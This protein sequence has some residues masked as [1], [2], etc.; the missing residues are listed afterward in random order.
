MSIRYRVGVDIGGTFTDFVLY[1]ALKGAF[2][3]HKRL[4]TADHPSHAALVGLKEVTDFAG[5]TLREVGE[6]VHGTT[7]VSN[8]LIERKGAKTGL[9][10]TDGFRDVLELGSEQRYDIY[11]LFL[12]FP[13][14]LVPRDLRLE[15]MERIDSGGAVV[16][17]LDI[18]S[19]RNALSQFADAGVESVAVCF[20]HSYR[21]AKHE[22]CVEEL[23]SREFPELSVSLS[24]AVDP[25]IREYPRCVTTCANAYVRPIVSRYLG[26]IESGLRAA[27]F[28]GS[29]RLMH[30]GGGMLSLETARTFPIRLLESGPAGGCLVSALFGA[31]SGLTDVIGF[32]M[33]GTTAKACLVEGGRIETIPLIEIAR[34][35]R[36]TKGSGLP[37][38]TPAVDMVEV[39]AGGGSIASI[40]DA[41]LLKV[42]PESAGANPGPA[43]YGM[44][45]DHPTVTDANLLLGYYNP[46][47][48]LGG[49]MHLDGHASERAFERVTEPLGLT[50]IEAASGVRKLVN[51]NM[52]SAI[53][54]H[55][56]ERGK[57]PRNYAIV[58]IGGA[59]PAHVADVA[60]NVGAT[61]AIVPP[62]SGAASALGFLS[63]P[64]SFEVIRSFLTE[65]KEDFACNAV[66]RLLNELEI[67][68]RSH[69]AGTGFEH[70]DVIVERMADMRLVGQTHEIVV[71]LPKG[72]LGPGSFAEIQAAFNAAYEERY[73][74]VNQNSQ[75][76]AINFRVRCSAP[77][78][79]LSI[80]SI[81]KGS[82]GVAKQKSTR[83][84]YFDEGVWETPVYN[85]YALDPGD[86]INGPAIIEEC[87]ST[88]VLSPNDY[89]I[90]DDHRNLCIS[91]A[92][93]KPRKSKVGADPSIANAIE[94]IEDDSVS[95]EIMWAR[96]INVVEE[97]WLTVRRTAYSLVISEAQDFACDLLDSD[98]ETLAHSPRAMPVFNLTLPNAVKGVLAKFPASTLNPGDV[99]ITNDPW[100][101]AGHLFDV[102][103]ITPAFV[104]G[105]LIGILATVGNVAD[106]GGTKDQAH[107]REI[108]DEG[109]QIP[110]MKLFDAGKPNQTLVQLL[111]QNVR[112]SEHI[113]GDIYSFV[114][115]NAIGVDRLT[116]F[117]H[118]YRI[119]DLRALATVIQRK[120][121]MAMRAAIDAIPDGEYF[122]AA[123]NNPNGDK[124]RYPLKLTVRG[125]DIHLDFDGAPP[126]SPQGG[127]NCPLNYTKAH[128]TYPLKCMLT[129]RM[130]GNSGCY[131]PFSVSAPPGSV[132]NAQRPAAVGLRQRT[133]WYLAP[134]IFGGLATALPDRVQANTGLPFTCNIHGHRADGQVYSD[135]FFM[136]GGQ[137]ASSTRDGI[138]GLLWPT[139]ASNTSVEL[140]ESRI[141]ILVLEK[142]YIPDSGGAG[143]HRGGLGQRLSMRK[144]ANDGLSTFAAVYPEG[145]ELPVEGLFGGKP[146]I[147]ASARVIDSAGRHRQS[148]GCGALVEL[149]DVSEIL[150]VIVSGGS[151]YGDRLE[152]PKKLVD[153]DVQM[154]FVSEAA[155]EE[156]YA[157]HSR[158]GNCAVAGE[159]SDR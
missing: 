18:C 94:I 68:A 119:R 154:G 9:I 28:C 159:R 24:S 105:H 104:S 50:S 108:Y 17:H 58:G 88:T 19:L 51:E 133:G 144:L 49:C 98:G 23:A 10:T 67:E 74:Q 20:L 13:E 8:A 59:G 156:I 37:I 82:N 40:D 56:I 99:L 125:S 135:I 35:H 109:L 33:G 118:D 41:G 43:C 53:K 121:E 61:R 113:L 34:V 139:S 136:G 92:P 39:G 106:I 101:C 6:I 32:D 72:A 114:T 29:L 103:V 36:F 90:V 73:T 126:L 141:P 70:G 143:R 63:A 83:P 44:D 7:L 146:G 91:V 21:N 123:W 77:S 60:R 86:C 100:L 153:R 124:L 47:F 15:V 5:I 14:P 31:A 157:R 76:E 11:D 2:H 4:T 52:A 48:F 75:I 134:G 142:S 147:T 12:R 138:S 54:G 120:S 30:S 62:A 112:D 57:D 102:V 115:A 66:N 16:T 97:M 27:G 116:S 65:I 110:P 95:L 117:L 80:A 107:A 84:A 111:Q 122:G 155:A 45:G 137:G 130:R 22:I 145:V 46:D 127:L 78:P 79:G 3:V 128:A 132:L 148:C 25:Q 87:E 85:R 38:Q 149:R 71:A 93:S 96:L 1:D 89:L 64:L 26:C 69:L 42:G 129:P 140:F 151:G 150:E 158:E 152:R 55:L 131:R 81:R